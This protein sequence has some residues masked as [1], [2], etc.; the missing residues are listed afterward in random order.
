M[1]HHH[2][3]HATSPGA[4]HPLGDVLLTPF[5]NDVVGETEVELGLL[6][7]LLLANEEAA[8]KKVEDED[9]VPLAKSTSMMSSTSS[10]I[11]RGEALQDFVRRKAAQSQYKNLPPLAQAAAVGHKECWP[12]LPI[13]EPKHE[14]EEALE[15]DSSSS[16]DREI[17]S[18]VSRIAVR[19]ASQQEKKS[20]EVGFAVFRI[21]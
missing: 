17:S 18:P 19:R 21:D 8:Q 16:S 10:S 4:A 12:T 1:Y 3:L 5:L 20:A 11:G 6:S 7:R 9:H 14:S 2:H 15:E 13:P